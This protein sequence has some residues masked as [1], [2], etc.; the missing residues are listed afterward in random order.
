M[1]DRKK[2]TVNDQEALTAV[3]E[4]ISTIATKGQ[5]ENL[6]MAVFLTQMVAAVGA[7]AVAHG[8]DLEKWKADVGTLVRTHPVVT[9]EVI[10]VPQD[11]N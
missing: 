5:T 1:G 8:Q 2:V 7:I 11:S 4:V 6:H 9:F 10:Q 3:A